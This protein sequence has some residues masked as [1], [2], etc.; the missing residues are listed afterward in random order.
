LKGFLK[1][2]KPEYNPNN[3]PFEVARRAK[4]IEPVF[5]PYAPK[6]EI[7][8]VVKV[9]VEK[10][11]GSREHPMGSTSFYYTKDGRLIG[12]LSL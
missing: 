8:T 9:T 3:D 4:I 10:G 7:I 1:V 11:D 2:S 6:M 12:E 5:N